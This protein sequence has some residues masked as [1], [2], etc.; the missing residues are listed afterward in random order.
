MNKSPKQIA[1]ANRSGR[2]PFHRSGFTTPSL[3]SSAAVPAVA[4][5]GR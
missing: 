5:L 1:P 3:R 2:R 4:E